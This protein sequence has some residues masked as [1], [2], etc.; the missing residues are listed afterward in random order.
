MSC[1]AALPTPG[2]AHTPLR[3]HTTHLPWPANPCCPGYHIAVLVRLFSP[4]RPSGH[5][6]PAATLFRRVWV[7]DCKAR[8]RIYGS[9]ARSRSS[10]IFH[11]PIQLLDYATLA[12]RHYVGLRFHLL[13]GCTDVKTS[14]PSTLS[15]PRPPVVRLLQLAGGGGGLGRGALQLCVLLAGGR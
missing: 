14:F 6:A 2:D 10:H 3:S 13:D 5:P 4:I 11:K 9:P 8:T 15:L 1:N 7:R 12:Q